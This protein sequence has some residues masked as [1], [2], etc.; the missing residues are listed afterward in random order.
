VRRCAFYT[1]K[2]GKKGKSLNNVF[3]FILFAE[4]IPTKSCK[5]YSTVIL[6]EL[7]SVSD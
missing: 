7:L 5:R 4:K 3:D 2:E 6:K 1:A